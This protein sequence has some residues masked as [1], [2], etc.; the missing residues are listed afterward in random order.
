[1]STFFHNKFWRRP[2]TYRPKRC[3]YN[4]EDED[5]SQNILIHKNYQVSCLK[6]EDLTDVKTFSYCIQIY[7]VLVRAISELIDIYEYYMPVHEFCVVTLPRIDLYYVS[8]F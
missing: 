8:V 3:E 6:T 2:K 5:H 4:C 1:M 7:D